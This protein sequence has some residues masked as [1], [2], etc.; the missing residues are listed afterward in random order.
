VTV[1]F[2]R[3]VTQ[4]RQSQHA[5]EEVIW[6]LTTTNVGSSPSSQSC[7]VYDLTNGSADVTSTVMPTNSPTVSG[8]VITLSPLKLL[9]AGQI[10]QVEVTYTTGGSVIVQPFVVIC[11]GFTYIGDLSTDLDK[12]RFYIGDTDAGDG[13][14]PEDANFSDNELDG[15]ITS[16][17]SWQRAVAAGFETMAAR[18][19]RYPDF[20]ADGLSLNRTDIADGYAEDAA[21]WRRRYGGSSGGAGSRAVTRQDGYSDDVDNVTD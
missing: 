19:R 5:S 21:K 17:G 18:W 7:K 9:T 15:L 20:R 11:E 4:G 14:L 10:Y 8:D 3:D 6:S 1:V 2:K 12:V 13:P 16:E